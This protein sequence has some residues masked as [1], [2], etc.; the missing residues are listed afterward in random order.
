VAAAVVRIMHRGSPTLNWTGIT[1]T[2]ELHPRIS[3]VWR[4]SAIKQTSD[5]LKAYLEHWPDPFAAAS[6]THES[7]ESHSHPD[8]TAGFLIPQRRTA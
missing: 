8:L 2:L 7:D 6:N 1:M 3:R 4:Q 5:L